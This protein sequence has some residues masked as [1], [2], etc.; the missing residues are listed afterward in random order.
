[1]T[2]VM[3]HT[4]QA[5][6]LENDNFTTF[7]SNDEKIMQKADL[8]EHQNIRSVIFWAKIIFEINEVVESAI[9]AFDSLNESLYVT[10]KIVT[11]ILMNWTFNI[12]FDIK[13]HQ[14]TSSLFKN[15]LSVHDILHNWV[16][17]LHS[18]SDIRDV[19]IANYSNMSLSHTS[20][21]KFMFFTH[22]INDSKVKNLRRDEWMIF[23]E[24]IFRS[25][26]THTQL[27]LLENHEDS[28]ILQ[29]IKNTLK[30]VFDLSEDYTVKL[31][32]FIS[33]IK[34][35]TFLNQYRKFNSSI[36]IKRDFSAFNMWFSQFKNHKHIIQVKQVTSKKNHSTIYLSYQR[37]Y[38]NDKKC[39]LIKDFSRLQLMKT[40]RALIAKTQTLLCELRALITFA[41]TDKKYV[42][43]LR[44]FNRFDYQFDLKNHFEVQIND[45]KWT[46]IILVKSFIFFNTTDVSVVLHCSL[47][48]TDWS[49][50]KLKLTFDLRERERQNDDKQVL[51]YCLFNASNVI[52]VCL[53]MSDKL[54]RI[55]IATIRILNFAHIDEKYYEYNDRFRDIILSQ[56]LRIKFTSVLFEDLNLSTTLA[57][58]NIELNKSQMSIMQYLQNLSNDFDL[59]KKFFE[60]EKT[61]MNVVITML[62]LKLSKKVKVLSSFNNTADTF[63]L[64]LNEQLQWLKNKDIILMN[65]KIIRFHLQFTERQIVA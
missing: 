47:I 51:Q 45:D 21:F 55:K 3:Y 14:V 6:K 4:S 26:S 48:K 40:Q 19:I 49:S 43:L 50:I 60:I 1:V 18:N 64:K 10:C 35:D 16:F 31:K 63:I 29:N 58:W 61:L 32:I 8:A 44:L 28:S 7:I 2:D 57:E 11:K 39:W 5:M 52:S 34:Q 46:A 62:L 36:K 20:Y 25:I 24:F 38:C 22:N 15:C 33:T 59:I 17:R 53:I 30:K 41:R 9:D 37:T 12:H 42:D 56:N 27:I 54:D 65:K 23:L 13:L